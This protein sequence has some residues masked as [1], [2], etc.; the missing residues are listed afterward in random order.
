[1]TV[2]WGVLLSSPVHSDQKYI[3]QKCIIHEKSPIDT[4]L[5]Y[6]VEFA[7]GNKAWFN[8]RHVKEESA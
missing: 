5:C 1:M 2:R 8:K 7:D 6:L 3:G 4:N